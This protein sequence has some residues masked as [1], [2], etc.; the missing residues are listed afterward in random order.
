MFYV[1]IAQILFLV[2]FSVTHA[3]VVTNIDSQAL[4][5]IER[6]SYSNQMSKKLK[7]FGYTFVVGFGGVGKTHLVHAFVS[8]LVDDSYDIVWWVDCKKDINQQLHQLIKNINS[9]FENANIPE[10]AANE[11]VMLENI[12]HFIENKKIKALLI[13]DSLDD[14]TLINKIFF[15]S[16][17][18]NLIITSRVDS[19]REATIK[20]ENFSRPQSISYLEKFLT[21]ASK[22]ELNK[23]AET[24]KD[25]PIALSQSAIFLHN[26]KALS[27]DEYIKLYNEDLKTL[28]QKEEH[29]LLESDAR[30][31]SVKSTLKLSLSQL[32][33]KKKI[34]KKLLILF[35]LINN[36]AISLDLIKEV[37]NELGEDKEEAIQAVSELVNR[38][39]IEISRSPHNG[40]PSF[41]MHEITQ[42]MLLAVF[43]QSDM[44]AIK[45][46]I[47]ALSKVIL[48]NFERNK[49]RIILFSKETP[50]YIDHAESYFEKKKFLGLSIIKEELFIK[51]FMLD[52]L[53]YVKRD[54]QKALSLIDS[55][56]PLIESLD[57][58]NL[59]SRFYSSAGDVL[60][61]HGEGTKQGDF[62]FQKMNEVL[63][64]GKNLDPHEI[65]RLNN[66]IGQA[67]LLK[68]DPA[69]S[70]DHTFR[71]LELIS[72]LQESL[73][74]IPTYY[75][76]AWTC[77]E[78]SDYE[79]ALDLL[80]K[81]IDLFDRVPD[82][83]I[84]FY[85]YNFKAL[86][87]LKLKKY[88]E[89]KKLCDLSIENCKKYFGSYESDTL[90]EAFAF[91]ANAYLCSGNFEKGIE[92]TTESIR[93][94][95]D[96]YKGTDKVLDQVYPWI[97]KGD[98]HLMRKELEKAHTAYVKAITIFNVFKKSK[99]SDRCKKTYKKVLFISSSLKKRNTFESYKATYQE[100]FKEEL[101][102][103]FSFYHLT[104][105]PNELIFPQ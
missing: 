49:H 65:V 32:E 58:E 50:E 64:K 38:F 73:I 88:K 23:L 102:G 97:I 18:L 103:Q 45:E 78:L 53:L 43:A 84:K 35:S 62:V 87:L 75:F 10:N 30:S 26:N 81:A 36:Q 96:F 83:A 79:K 16:K 19:W 60:S 39:Y 48:A 9:N 25:Y 34:S 74:K 6:D 40:K 56:L 27:V 95:N 105:S 104:T 92:D 85:N 2:S 94:Y 61:L 69:K 14:A 52:Y 4:H 99:I 7:K 54:H 63:N 11:K 71:S 68:A 72:N 3:S 89:A 29:V 1:L 86:T 12:R 8:K 17:S 80:N 42:Q 55:I 57:N 67:Y 76:S 90:A 91:R 28:W 44:E 22:N 70:K 47:K 100:I 20:L 93:V 13:L 98:C 15:A 59:K 82:T 5:D 21:I 24:L 37:I 31:R 66:S 41:F 51:I 77:I 33:Q 101:G 46:V